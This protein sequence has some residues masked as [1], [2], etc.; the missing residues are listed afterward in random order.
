M[1]LSSPLR[2]DEDLM[3]AAKTTGAAM[4]RSAAQ[5]INHWARIGRELEGSRVVRHQDVVS[6]LS[7][8]L[9]Y[10]AAGPREQAVVRASWEEALD[11]AAG[12]D[13]AGK[14]AAAGDSWTELDRAGDVVTR[15][16]P[17]RR[18]RR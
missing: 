7:G 9:P 18:R 3:A 2:V 10:D 13:M 17:P 12:V 6:V 16:A 1:A 15:V 4:S 14:F 8:E 11:A 5:Q